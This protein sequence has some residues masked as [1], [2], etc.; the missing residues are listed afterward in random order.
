MLDAEPDR[1]CAV[2]VRW[3]LA[4]VKPGEGLTELA[5]EYG[6]LEMGDIK[7]VL[8]TGSVAHLNIGGR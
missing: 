1:E 8:S 2:F 7:L 4:C 5:R 6:A 3:R